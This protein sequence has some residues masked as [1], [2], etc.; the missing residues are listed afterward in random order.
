MFHSTTI[1]SI[2]IKESYPALW[3]PAS[4]AALNVTIRD[5]LWEELPQSYS[6]DS[7]NYYR[8]AVYNYVSQLYGNVA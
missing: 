7:I 6:D 4:R 3:R 1:S 5:L 8:D 2:K